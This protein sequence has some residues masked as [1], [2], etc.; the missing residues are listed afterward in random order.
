MHRV[1][2][3]A[4]LVALI[5]FTIIVVATPRDWLAAFAIYAALLAAA[6]VVARIPPIAVIRRMSIEIPFVVFAGLLPFIAL[7]PRVEVLG[8]PLAV[9]GLWGAWALLAKATLALL[10]AT[11]L[12]STTEPRHIVLALDGLGLPRQLASIAAFMLR[13]LDVIVDESRRMRIARD[14]RG[15]TPRGPRGWRVLARSIA[16]LFVRSH[17]RGERVHLAMLARGYGDALAG[18]DEVDGDAG[19]DAASPATV[20]S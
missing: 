13:Y 18:G 4:K 14:A 11:V 7:G 3:R 1:S 12:I 16:A 20:A 10:A 2:P 6:I 9:E 15:F 17:A 8:V 19:S 5:V